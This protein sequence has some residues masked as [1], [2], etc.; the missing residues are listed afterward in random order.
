MQIIKLITVS[1]SSTFGYFF[2]VQNILLT[3]LFSNICFLCPSL[4]VRDNVS[5]LYK[6]TGKITELY[7]LI[8]YFV[9]R[10]EAVTLCILYAL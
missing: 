8:L 9:D 2:L 5:H 6:T 10:T 3:T 4:K 7:F 1:F